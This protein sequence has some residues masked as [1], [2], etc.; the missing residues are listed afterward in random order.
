MTA[1]LPPHPLAGAL[2]GLRVI[3]FSQ[4][5]AGPL[6]TMI[7]ADLGAEVIKIEPPTGDIGRS[8]GPPFVGEESAAFLSLN[9]NKKGVVIDLKTPAGKAEA[10]R[11]I[12]TADI[13][14]ESFRP[15]VA[16]RLGIGYAKASELKP[17]LVYC[18]VSAYG[19][20]GPWA[21]RPGVDGVIQAISGLMSITGGASEPPSKVQAPIADMATGYQA[22]IGVLAALQKRNLTG[23]GCHLDISLF[24]SA[25]LLQQVPLTGY[26]ASGEVPLR[27][28]SGAPYA[29]PNEAYETADGHILI[30]AYQ[31][32]RWRT[33]CDVVGA[34][35]LADDARFGDLV[36]RMQNRGALSDRLN[37]ILRRHTTDHWL[38]LLSDA[39][40][41]CA[42]ICDYSQV[43][44][45][46]QIAAAGIVTTIDHA[47]IGPFRTLGFAIGASAPASRLPPPRLGEH[48]EEILGKPETDT[49]APQQSP[50]RHKRNALS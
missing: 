36:T 20:Q 42:P 31:P 9:R 24:A 46:E 35:E 23:E 48:D 49:A 33:L 22:A 26:L 47:T 4:I 5:A 19:Q 30:A 2:A 16:D 29:T 11:L 37:A 28:G 3:D 10:H 21:D 17:D 44:Q 18:S 43:M 27:A 13:V 6:C 39:D 15:G 50:A 7:L 45:L 41:I 34:P 38:R 25:L 14:V 32:G 12:G 1:S 8:L 40:I